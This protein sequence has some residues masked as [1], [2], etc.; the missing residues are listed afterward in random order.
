VRCDFPGSP[1]FDHVVRQSD[2]AL[3]TRDGSIESF[4]H[5][6]YVR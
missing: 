5:S 4:R 1:H 6:R 2:L 3:E